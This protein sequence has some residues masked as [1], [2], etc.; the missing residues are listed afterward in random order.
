M[1]SQRRPKRRRRRRLAARKEMR[2]RKRTPPEKWRA[3]DAKHRQQHPSPLTRPHEVDDGFS[4][5]EGCDT[6]KHSGLVVDCDY[7]RPSE[8]LEFSTQCMLHKYD[9]MKRKGAPR[10]KKLRVFEE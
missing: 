10:K 6:K 9:A 5:V 8:R 3:L 4:H 7:A 1:A 2:R